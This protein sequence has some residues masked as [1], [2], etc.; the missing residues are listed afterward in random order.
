MASDSKHYN[1]LTVYGTLGISGVYYFPTTD[2]ASGQALP[3]IPAGYLQINIGGVARL[4]P[5]Y[6]YV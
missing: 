3:A 2:G 6:D 4:M 1:D 5:Y